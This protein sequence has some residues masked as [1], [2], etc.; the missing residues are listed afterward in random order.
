MIEQLKEE[1]EIL[2]GQVKKKTGC[3][4]NT[5][6]FLMGTTFLLVLAYIVFLLSF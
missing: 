2:I 5:C 6:L 4:T 1:I 3:S